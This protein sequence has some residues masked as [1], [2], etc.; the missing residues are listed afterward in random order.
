VSTE[1]IN[2][3]AIAAFLA[4]AHARLGL[5]N[6]TLLSVSYG[7]SGSRW[8]VYGHLPPPIGFVCESATTLEE[9]AQKY[10]AATDKETLAAKLRSEA[11]RFMSEA[12]KM[13]GLQ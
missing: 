12:M 10:K 7:E 2:E 1:T 8:N 13:E 5:D 3:K 9:A 11:D 6:Q 4:D